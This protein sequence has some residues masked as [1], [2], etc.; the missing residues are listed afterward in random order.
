[1]KTITASITFQYS[2]R[3]K[4]ELLIMYVFFFF[5]CFMCLAG[6]CEGVIP[7][8]ILAMLAMVMTLS[9]LLYVQIQNRRFCERMSRVKVVSID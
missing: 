6:I 7:Y 8:E 9:F 5:A 4:I 3:A 1:M 2:L